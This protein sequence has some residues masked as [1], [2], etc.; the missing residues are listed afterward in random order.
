MKHGALTLATTVK[1]TQTSTNAVSQFECT[2]RNIKH[3]N[4]TNSTVIKINHRY[5]YRV[6]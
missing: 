3:K 4:S 5:S 1:L 2:L 6:N